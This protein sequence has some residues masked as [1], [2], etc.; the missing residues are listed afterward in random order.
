MKLE[1]ERVK[2]KQ[3]KEKVQEVR[4][5]EQEEEVAGVHKCV[6]PQTCKQSL[7]RP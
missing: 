1:E 2:V 6:P 7:R 3:Y 5:E 4:L